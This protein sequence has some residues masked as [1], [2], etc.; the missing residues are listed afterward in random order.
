MKVFRIAAMILEEAKTVLPP[1]PSSHVVTKQHLAS[2]GQYQLD[3]MI[4]QLLQMGIAEDQAL[5]E[6]A[7]IY[8][9]YRRSGIYGDSGAFY[10]TATYIRALYSDF[11]VAEQFQAGQ[12]PSTLPLYIVVATIGAT[13]LVLYYVFGPRPTMRTKEYKP[14]NAWA[15]MDGD[16]F[17]GLYPIARSDKGTLVF[18]RI[19]TWETIGYRMWQHH[20]IQEREGNLDRIILG[21]AATARSYDFPQFVEWIHSVWHADFLGIGRNFGTDLIGVSPNPKVFQY[22]PEAFNQ[23]IGGYTRRPFW[24]PY[25]IDWSAILDWWIR[26]TPF[27]W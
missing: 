14:K 1:L 22:F 5:N 17:W 24:C 6:I 16:T 9:D 23:P 7:A 27:K 8:A 19:R 25:G 20:K 2:L 10:R 4:W 18:Q 3:E 26:G 15:L 13:I 21:S 11:V 12:P